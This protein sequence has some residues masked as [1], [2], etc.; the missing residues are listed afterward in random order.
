MEC[1]LRLME[2]AEI[3]FPAS[4]N[5]YAKHIK[6]NSYISMLSTNLLEVL[7]VSMKAIRRKSNERYLT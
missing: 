1:L 6:L 4:Q 5:S 2:G 7:L 3:N